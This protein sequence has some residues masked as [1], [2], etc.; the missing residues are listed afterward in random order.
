MADGTAYAAAAETA[1]IK[2]ADF[3]RSWVLDLRINY[4]KF[5][6]NHIGNKLLIATNKRPLIKVLVLQ[7]Y[8]VLSYITL[9]LP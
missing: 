3:G 5:N 9:H 8:T 6:S 2:S 4:S 7:I 1:N